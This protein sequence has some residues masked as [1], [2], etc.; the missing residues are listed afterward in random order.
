MREMGSEYMSLRSTSLLSRPPLL[1]RH[2]SV[3]VII[4]SYL[5]LWYIHHA[6]ACSYLSLC[7]GRECAA[8]SVCLGARAIKRGYHPPDCTGSGGGP[9]LSLCVQLFTESGARAG[10]CLR[11]G[12]KRRLALE[13]VSR[14]HSH[15]SNRFKPR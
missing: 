6:H 15:F 7:M 14:T 10:F 8:F 12:K 13:A 5:L 1:L 3:I 4:K 2:S 9:S 11:E